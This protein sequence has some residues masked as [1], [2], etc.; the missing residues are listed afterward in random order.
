MVHMMEINL[1]LFF[2]LDFLILFRTNKKS[3]D[4]G[5]PPVK[6]RILFICKIRQCSEEFQN[7]EALIAHKTAVHKRTQCT[8]CPD[9]K[10][11]VDLNKHLRVAHNIIQNSMCEHC[12]QVFSGT[13]S[14]LDHIQRKHEVREPLQCD[15]CKD[16][17]KNRDTIRSHMNYVHIQGPQPCPV[18]DI[19]TELKLILFLIF[20]KPNVTIHLID[21]RK[22][23]SESKGAP[24]TSIDS[25]RKF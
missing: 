7:K 8:F 21:L 5:N 13:R 20:H 15:I 3:L 23:I 17:F 18:C 4:D 19:F 16:F 10:L 9:L 22:N 25:R 1:I 11:V 24:E 14:L 6:N 2:S 12:G